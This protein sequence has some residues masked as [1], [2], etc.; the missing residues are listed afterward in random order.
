MPGHAS[1]VVEMVGHVRMNVR[2]LAAIDMYGS[3][4]S[5]RRRRIIVA[6]FLV[7][8]AVAAAISGWLLLR[9]SRPADWVL[10]LCALGVSLNYASLSVYAVLLSRPGSL[11]S[12]LAGVDVGPELRR[13]S[14]LQLW[15]FVPLLLLVLAIR[16]ELTTRH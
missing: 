3:R 11:D 2:R 5:M 1:A 14:V 6:E 16:D 13:Y 15:V 10:A 7:V 9:A 8:T 4:G 12:E